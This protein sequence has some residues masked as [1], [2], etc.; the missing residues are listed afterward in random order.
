M[1]GPTDDLLFSIIILSLRVMAIPSAEKM[2]SS[3]LNKEDLL[4]N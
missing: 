3:C 2:G 4:L 1:V